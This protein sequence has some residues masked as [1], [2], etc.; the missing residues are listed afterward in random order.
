[1][2]EVI[3]SDVAYLALKAAQKIYGKATAEL[4][5][6]EFARVQTVARKQ[7]QL[8][9]RMLAAPEARDAMVPPSTLELAL[10]EIRGRYP[11]RKNSA[12]TWRATV[13]MKPASPARWNAK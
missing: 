8:E 1:M 5:P 10:Q 9:T 11:A 7:H 6:E 13:W 4:Q 12:T 3:D 2:P